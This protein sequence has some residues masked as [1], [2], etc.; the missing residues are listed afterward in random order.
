MSVKIFIKRKFPKGR[1]KELFKCIRSIRSLVPK[2]SGYIS[3]EY[4]RSIEDANEIVTISTWFS[5][6]DWVAWFNSDQRKKIQA[7]IDAIDGVTSE[8]TV[9]RYIKTR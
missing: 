8:H 9:Y 5:H 7:K 4:L 1:E 6:D 3:G 2:Q